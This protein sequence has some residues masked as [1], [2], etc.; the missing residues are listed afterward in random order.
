MTNIVKAALK[1][2]TVKIVAYDWLEDSLQAQS[3]KKESKYRF[4][5]Q[6][7][8][9]KANLRKHKNKTFRQRNKKEGE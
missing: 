1:L 9:D 4:A 3:H 6:K 2:Q 7:Q 8:K 5:I